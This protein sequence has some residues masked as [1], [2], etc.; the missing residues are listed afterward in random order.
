MP[1]L[2]RE[3][4]A[5]PSRGIPQATDVFEVAAFGAEVRVCETRDG[6]RPRFRTSYHADAA[7]AREHLARLVARKLRVGFREVGAPVLLGPADANVERRAPSALALETLFTSGDP[8]VL[9]EVLATTADR[10]LASLA[11]PWLADGRPEMRR[12]LLAYVDDGCDRP[13]HRALVKGLF[14]GAEAHGDD[15]LLA[16]FAVAFD[17]LTPRIAT[18]RWGWVGGD[19][20]P[21][22][23]VL[24]PNPVLRVRETE[25][26]RKHTGP[27]RFTRATR[28]YLA[29]RVFRDLRRIAK[30]DLP[31]YGRLVRTMLALYEDVHLPRPESLLDAWTLVHVLWGWSPVLERDPRGVR[32]AKGRSL[33]EL[34]PAPYH[35]AAFRGVRDELLAL[36]VTA[37]SRVVR[38][39]VV[40]WL[41]KEYAS[42]LAGVPLATIRALLASADGVVSGLGAKLLERAEGLSVMPVDAWLALLE[43]P[44]PS[45][46]AVVVR[47]FEARVSPKRLTLE[48]CAR[49][50]RSPVAVVAELGLRT[51][52]DK[53]I[54]TPADLAAI[55]SI[56]RTAQVQAVREAGARWTLELLS[57][58][59]RALARPEHLRD[60]FD[61]KHP[62]VRA[63]AAAFAIAHPEHRSLPLWFS[64]VE[65][66]YEDVRALV[67]RF[68]SEWQAEAGVSE[69]EHLAATA[70]LAIHRGAASKPA[71][72]RRLADRVVEKPE[73][74]DRLLPV[75]ALALRSVRGPERTSALASVARAA[76]RSEAVR[77]AV[78]RHL[79][80]LTVGT[81]VVA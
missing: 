74:V 34:A 54:T 9:E 3:R 77:A 2:E 45:A 79:P 29:R 75:L 51:A 48:A 64:L 33:A 20:R 73:E 11:V 36:L 62:E 53:P 76:V 80:E 12:A 39:W 37:R 44:D 25:T 47:L 81:E 78:R 38:A 70:I 58:G 5:D 30:A 28:R 40:Q 22:A 19:W 4:A 14:K 21:V 10:R 18:L 13:G 23:H 50:A 61:A 69:I 6:H 56:A 24:A 65:S 26:S 72:M 49:L 42:E 1:R 8:S 16:H 27:E 17:R 67:V 68:A 59:A 63:I 52:R 31:R 43:S 46:V 7:G 71:V 66:P 41:E 35:P 57:G 55:A 60:L 32:V 15:E